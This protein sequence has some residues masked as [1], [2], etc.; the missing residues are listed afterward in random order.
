[1][2]EAGGQSSSPLDTAFSRDG[3]TKV[4]VQDRMREHAEELWRW[5]ERGGYFFVCGD[6]SRMANDVNQA[7]IDIAS[8]QGGLSLDEAKG[9]VEKLKSDGQYVRDVY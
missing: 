4:Y 9:F 7:L 3:D 5:I 1:M 8:Q 6:A 2:T